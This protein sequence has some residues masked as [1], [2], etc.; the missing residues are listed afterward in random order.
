MKKSLLTLVVLS[1]HILMY[2]QYGYKY[3]EKFIELT[4]DKS[5]PI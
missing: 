1:A 2:G 3:Q 4:P 5:T